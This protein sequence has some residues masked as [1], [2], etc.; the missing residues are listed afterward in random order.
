MP[1]SAV[2]QRYLNSCQS[3]RWLAHADAMPVPGAAPFRLNLEGNWRMDASAA[4]GVLS[5]LLP[6]CSPSLDRRFSV[7]RQRLVR[8]ALTGLSQVA[9]LWRGSPPPAVCLAAWPDV[10][11]SHCCRSSADTGTGWPW[12]SVAPRLQT[13]PAPFT[14]AGCAIASP[15]PPAPFVTN[16]RYDLI[17]GWPLLR[18][19]R[20]A[21]ATAVPQLV[22]G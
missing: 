2:T 3:W 1:L 7:R 20:L 15:V 18:Q 14:G 16:D 17:A 22:A 12:D 6:R 21:S 9:V 13:A 5:A 4:V 8:P 19:P 10:P 11:D